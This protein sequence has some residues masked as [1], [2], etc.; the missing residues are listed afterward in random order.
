MLQGVDIIS[1]PVRDQE[2][3]LKF[4]TEKLD[5]KLSPINTSAMASR[6]G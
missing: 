3:A 6:D 2:A 5:S 1:I 4:Y